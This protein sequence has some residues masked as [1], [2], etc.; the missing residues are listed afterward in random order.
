MTTRP[1]VD[2]EIL[3]L[4]ELLPP[5]DLSDA[6][7]VSIRELLN[8][9]NPDLPK[10]AIDP[11][12]RK[13][14]GLNGAPEVPVLLFDPPG[15]KNRAAIYHI[16]GGGMVMGTAMSSALGTAALALDL[17][18]LI[19]S[20]EYRLAPENPFPAPHEDC[21]AGY[22][23]LVANA[24]GLGVDKD[25]IA[26]FGESAGGNLAASL[27]L[28]IRDTGRPAPCAQVLTYPMLDYR[29]GS[30]AMPAS[31]ET[32][33]FI[34]TREH[35][36]YAWTAIKG[37]YA[38]DD[39]RVGWYSPTHAADLSKLPPAWIGV[40]ALDLFLEEDLEYARRLTTAG[41]PV[42]TQV[43]PGCFHAFNM[44]PTAQVAQAYDRDLR[45]AIKGYL[46]L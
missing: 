23:W 38:L 33:E 45:A 31:A 27:A 4:L 34:W 10:P 46:K 16:H 20:V 18:V 5:L 12:E 8:T 19:V 7:I 14:P 17:D 6:S 2:P 13:V 37:S 11:V 29:T 39:P 40:G 42:E 36:Q 21:L 22:D 25:R 26:I 15:R 35:N 32:G 43:Y 30:E 3:P 41:V 44:V 1:L 9:P 24:E 28:M